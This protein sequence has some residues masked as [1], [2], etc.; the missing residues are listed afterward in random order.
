M[1]IGTPT[2]PL[3][4]VLFCPVCGVQHIDAPDPEKG[5][6]NPPH[7]SHLCS[8]CGLVWRP[9]DIHTTGVARVD[10][11]GASDTWEPDDGNAEIQGLCR[12]VGELY[13]AAGMPDADSAGRVVARVKALRDTVLGTHMACTPVGRAGDVCASC[14]ADME[15]AADAALL[16]PARLVDDAPGAFGVSP[17]DSSSL[18]EIRQAIDDHLG[19]RDEESEI[20]AAYVVR[21]Q[22]VGAEL[23]G[24][25]ELYKAVLL[26]KQA[27]EDIEAALRRIREVHS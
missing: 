7:R 4:L 8:G 5:W 14:G 6:D 27:A 3:P 18:L 2:N 10:T 9:A 24:L 15:D 17:Q 23:R 16:C 26:K 21:V 19:W 25:R 13:E 1:S 11:Q 12:L 20:A 22:Q